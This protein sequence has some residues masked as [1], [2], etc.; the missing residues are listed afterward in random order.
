MIFDFGGGTLDCSIV[1]CHGYD[2]RVQAVNGDPAL[3]GIDF[4]NVIKEMIMKKVRKKLP[5]GVTIKEE[6]EGAIQREAEVFKKILSDSSVAKR[7]ISIDGKP[8]EVQIQRAKFWKKVEAE[9][10]RRRAISVAKSAID[11]AIEYGRTDK[12]DFIVIVGGTS[13]IP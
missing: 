6:E 5:K 9:G 11:K 3:G 12:I 1:R 4:D 2:C 10:I 8:Y 13:K 7:P